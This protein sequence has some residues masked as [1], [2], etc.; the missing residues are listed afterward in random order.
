MMN[1]QQQSTQQSSNQ[2]FGANQMNNNQLT[3]F[4]FE[5]ANVQAITDEKGGLWFLAK[6]VA[7]ILEYSDA[8]E[9]TK[10]LESYEIQNLQLAGFGNRGVNFISESGLYSSITGSHKPEAKKF[11]KWVNSEVL[12]SIRKTGSYS[13]NKRKTQST[14]ILPQIAK[15]FRGALSITKMLGLSGNQA[16]LHADGA[17]QKTTGHSVIKLFDVELLSPN[18]ERHFNATTLA[19]MTGFKSAI[20]F[21]KELEAQGFQEK[22]KIGKDKWYWTPTEKGKVF[23]VLLD[24]PKSHAH[25][26]VQQLEWRESIKHELSKTNAGGTVHA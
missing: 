23:A 14:S 2:F 25:G 21:N 5:G 12:P 8:F 19:G 16:Y 3:T 11:K 1:T 9:M 26:T 20:A 4:N 17:V 7:E 24:R 15:E 13:T 10:K 18:Q 22:I 6:D